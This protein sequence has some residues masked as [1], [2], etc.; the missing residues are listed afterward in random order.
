MTTAVPPTTRRLRFRYGGM[1]L[2]FV[3]ISAAFNVEFVSNNLSRIIKLVDKDAREDMVKEVV[4]PAGMMPTTTTTNKKTIIIYICNDMYDK[5][6]IRKV[7]ELESYF[8]KN[9][10]VAT[11]EQDIR[12]DWILPAEQIIS[13]ESNIT[14]T[15]TKALSSYCCGQERSLMWLVLNQEHYDY[16]WIMEDD[17]LW[18]N[19]T[20]LKD[21]FQLYSHDDDTDLLHSN[22]GMEETSFTDIDRWW[23]YE[24]LFPP[25]VT[26]PEAAFSPP[27]HEGNYQFARLSSLFVA[28]LNSWRLQNNGEWTFFESLFSNLPFRNDTNNLKTK[29]FINNSIGYEFQN[30]WRPCFSLEQ[31]YNKSSTNNGGRGGLFH[32]VKKDNLSKDPSKD[33]MMQTDFVL[34]QPIIKRHKRRRHMRMRNGMM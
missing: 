1:T 32:P 23:P 25:Y 30:R 34:Q 6:Q 18:T 12:G 2:A 20:D 8:G 10:F 21:F 28:A 26:T 9:L 13:P 16:A 24:R 5:M 27:F 22:Y 15:R 14:L 19:F 4:V 33:C 7:R 3:A 31:V 11:D 17:V 29:S